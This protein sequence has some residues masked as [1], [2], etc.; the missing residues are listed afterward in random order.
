MN[1]FALENCT[2]AFC[3][4]VSGGNPKTGVIETAV[5]PGKITKKHLANREWSDLKATVSLAQSKG[6]LDWIQ[7]TMDLQGEKSR[8]NGSIIMANEDTLAMH[9]TE[10]FDTVLT[11]VDFPALAGDSKETPLIKFE[12]K[13]E[14]YKRKPGD[15]KKVEGTGSKEHKLLSCANFKVTTGLGDI[16]DNTINGVSGWG[17]VQEVSTESK[18][19]L[20]HGEHVISGVKF[21]NFDLKGSAQD[22]KPFEDYYESFVEQGGSG[23][24]KE[25]TIAVDF[26]YHD[27]KT[28]GFT[29]ELLNC[30]LTEIVIDDP[31]ASKNAVLKFTTKWYCEQMRFKYGPAIK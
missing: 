25:L 5:G 30:G 19:H 3:K 1:F 7:M 31:E 29:I 15:K 8:K 17:F 21:N 11:K 6:I 12:A 22:I 9:E 14:N 2:P 18:G 20:A 23:D 16:A 24:D 10:F 28:V 26:L 4:T 27:M 13:P